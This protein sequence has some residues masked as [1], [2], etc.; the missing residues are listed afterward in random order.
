MQFNESRL[1]AAIETAKEKANGNASLLRAIEK[2]AT[3]LR[4]AWIVSELHSSLLI[5]TESG[6]T[7]RA[8][9]TCGCKAFANGMICKHRVAYRIVALYNEIEETAPVAVSREELIADIKANTNPLELSA[10]LQRRAGVTRIDSR[11]LH[12]DTLRQI[13]E[14]V[15]A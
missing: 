11:W 6:E 13:H 3:G 2:A 10:W 1:N 5:T 14:A 4:G 9:G 7:Y 8:N 15:A 12:I